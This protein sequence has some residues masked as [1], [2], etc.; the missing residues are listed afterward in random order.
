MALI[1]AIAVFS[2]IGLLLLIRSIRWLRCKRFA[3]GTIS[4]LMSLVMFVAAAVI[5][6]IGNSLATYQRLTHEVPAVEVAFARTGERQYDAILTY[7]AG[8]RQRFAL[9]G[10]E[11]QIDARVLKWH[12][13]VNILGFDAAYRME[14]ISGRY[15]DVQSERSASRTVY[16]LALTSGFDVWELVRRYREWMPWIDAYYGSATYLPM[17]DGA[18]FEVKVSQSGLTARPLNL[19]ARQ[20]IGSWR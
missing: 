17:A 7:P 5:G 3:A 16:P 11:W 10:D 18:Q 9:R 1:G 20:A 2:F 12:P 6:L 13:F 15:S 8:A 4:A 14:R 19:A